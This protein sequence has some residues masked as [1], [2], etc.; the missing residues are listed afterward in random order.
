MGI[1]SSLIL[2]F[3]ITA[4]QLIRLPLINGGGATFLDITIIILCLIG[5][6]QTRLKLIKPP[7][8]ITAGLLFT[9]VALISL[10]VSPVKLLY[11]QYLSSFLYIIRFFSVI[12][13]GW[14]LASKTLISSKQ[15]IDK[16]LLLSGVALAI[17]GLLQFII[18]PDLSFIAV[19][20]WDPH[21]LRTVSTFLDPNFAGAFFVLT[22]LLLYKNLKRSK[23]WI[24]Y[25]ILVYLALLTTFSRSAYLAFLTSFI[26]FAFLQKS[27]K[28]GI[29][30]AVLSAG[31]ILGFSAYQKNVAQP[32]G[33]DRVKSA[34]SRFNTW[35]QGLSLFQNHPILGVGFNTYRY[36]LEQY[37]LGDKAFLS[38]RG[39]STN[40][41][42][43]LY[44]AATTGI[45][46]LT[47]F[48]FFL[49]SIVWTNKHNP[50]LIAGLFGMIIQS[51]FINI[52]FYPFILIWILL[53]SS[54]KSH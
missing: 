34:Q 37:N 33:V 31:L 11:Q 16:I 27:L 28:I 24:V 23:K 51:F 19:F 40:D 18:L 38:S 12:L 30:A 17:L 49:F 14:L 29:I 52:L 21:Y 15:N 4:G 20:G 35:Q 5:L 42:S 54:K 25:F 26:T 6:F 53:T 50:I 7:L 1:F 8:V 45:I 48:L 47:I 46:G 10:V 43:L 41:S 3:A 22:L 36:A 2:T 9:F 44:V 13:L 32:R 39:S